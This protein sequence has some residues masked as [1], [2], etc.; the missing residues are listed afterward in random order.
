MIGLEKEVVAELVREEHREFKRDQSVVNQQFN[1]LKFVN[2]MKTRTWILYFD[3][4]D[5][6]RSAKLVCDYSEMD[7]VVEELDS[8]YDRSGENTWEQG[9]GKAATTLTLTRQDWYFT[10]REAR[11]K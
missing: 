6:C 4:K 7:D 5:R 3:K 2:R 1:Y 8:R 10:V 11:N 9:R